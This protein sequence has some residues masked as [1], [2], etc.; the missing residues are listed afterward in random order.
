MNKVRAASERLKPTSSDIKGVLVSIYTHKG[1]VR[2][3][4]EESFRVPGHAER[5]VNEYGAGCIECWCEQLNRTLEEN[6]GVDGVVSHGDKG[7]FCDADPHPMRP[8]IGE[9]NQGVRLG[10][11][12]TELEESRDHLLCG[13][14]VVSLVGLVVV[15]PGFGVPDFSAVAGTDDRQVAAETGVFAQCGWN[16]HA[17]LFVWCLLVCTRE[18]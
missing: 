5:A 14:D 8:D 10:V 15:V 13:V 17:V 16:R 1:E 11:S 6:W 9:E 12:V 7:Q 18:E 2:E 3:S 4:L